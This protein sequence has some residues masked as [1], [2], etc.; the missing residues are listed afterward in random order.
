MRKSD[1]YN[2]GSARASRKGECKHG[3]ASL[4]QGRG[5]PFRFALSQKFNP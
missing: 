1:G 4:I 2:P 3:L 5:R